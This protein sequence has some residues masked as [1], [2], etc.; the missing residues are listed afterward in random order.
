MNLIADDLV[1][2]LNKCANNNDGILEGLPNYIYQTGLEMMCNVALE[3]RMGF[4]DSDNISE[5]VEKIMVALR[6]YQVAYFL[7]E[8]KAIQF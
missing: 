3:R 5:E 1:S 6:G 7:F 4:L 2:V 8:F